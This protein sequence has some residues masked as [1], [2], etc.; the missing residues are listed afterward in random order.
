M[1]AKSMMLAVVLL[2]QITSLSTAQEKIEGFMGVKW[3]TPC[4]DARDLIIARLEA[5]GESREAQHLRDL[6]KYTSKDSCPGLDFEDSIGGRFFYIHM[7]FSD[8]LQSVSFSFSSQVYESLL[9][10]FTALYGKPNEVKNS[11]LHNAMGA[12]FENQTATWKGNRG[13]TIVLE[14]M[15]D[16]V[17]EGYVTVMTDKELA[18]QIEEQKRRDQKAVEDLK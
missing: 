12:Q 2:S 3:G 4:R 5:K 18:R 16:K 14:R 17:N 8:G 13:A 7:D 10:A 11:I 6:I 15:F 1:K 9:E